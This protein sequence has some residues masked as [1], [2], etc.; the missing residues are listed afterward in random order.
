M[1]TTRYPRVNPRSGLREKWHDHFKVPLVTQRSITSLKFNGQTTA[2]HRV[3]L[4]NGLT[5][6]FYARLCASDELVITFHGAYLKRKYEHPRFERVRSLRGAIPTHIAVA[7]PTMLLDPSKKMLLSWYLGGPG[8]DPM[9]DILKV[10][11]RAKGRSG[12]KHVLFIGGS[13]GGHAALRLSAHLPG[14]LAYV[15]APATDIHRCFPTAKKNYFETVW[16]GWD[17]ESLLD[18]FPERFNMPELYRRRS[19]ENFVYYAQSTR[20]PHYLETHFEPFRAATPE[21]PTGAAEPRG[22]RWLSLYEGAKEGH[23]AMTPP[24]FHEHLDRALTWWRVQRAPIADCA[25]LVRRPP[26]LTR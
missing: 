1:P 23:G 13:G 25:P 15:Q 3:P 24:E 9:D 7:D 2:V 8:W 19:P 11:A 5:L 10:I 22:R 6:D 17:P 12:A 4:E 26:S 14:S 16:P 18:A 20:D 21:K